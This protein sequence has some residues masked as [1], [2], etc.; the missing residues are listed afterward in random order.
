M[1]YL[2]YPKAGAVFSVGSCMWAGSLS[3]NGYD[4]NV[5]VLTGNVLREFLDRA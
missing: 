2:E 5:S 4:N 3:Y 1:T